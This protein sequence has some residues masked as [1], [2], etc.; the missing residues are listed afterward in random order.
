MTRALLEYY[1][2]YVMNCHSLK[3]LI[4]V[5][6]L[7]EINKANKTVQGYYYNP[8]LAGG[9]QEDPWV[10][11]AFPYPGALYRKIRLVNDGRYNDMTGTIRGRVF[12]SV[13]FNK[14]QLQ[15]TLSSDPHVREH[16]PDTRPLNDLRGLNK[17]LSLYGAVYLKPVKGSFGLGIKKVDRTKNGYIFIHRKGTKTLIGK[18]TTANKLLR[19]LKASNRYLIQQSVAFIDNNKHVDFRVIMQKDGTGDWI[20]SGIVSR[21]GIEG[22]IYTNDIS[23]VQPGK[24]TLRTVFQLDED[25]ATEKER[26]IVSICKQACLVLEK[27]YGNYGDLGVD[28]IVDRELKV[29]L[30]EMNCQHQPEIAVLQEDPQMFYNVTTRPF[31]YAKSLAGFTKERTTFL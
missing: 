8:E 13:N 21:Y 25:Q 2:A 9:G 5:C 31:E 24:V 3:G 22:R 23:S 17:M 10:K 30:L 29:W 11:G 20:C 19:R 26:E 27:F 16:L 28:V 12:N 14:W 1:R 7:N 6:S 15:N 4:Y 18:R